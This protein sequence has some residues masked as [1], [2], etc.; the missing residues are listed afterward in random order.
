MRMSGPADTAP[1]TLDIDADGSL[2]DLQSAANRRRVGVALSGA[3]AFSK[4]A[5]A[6]VRNRIGFA[7]PGL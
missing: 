4:Q 5:P 7:I 2:S 6:P 3:R 1:A